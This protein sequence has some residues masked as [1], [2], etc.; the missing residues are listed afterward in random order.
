MSPIGLSC[1]EQRKNLQKIRYKNANPAIKQIMLSAMSIDL[2]FFKSPVPPKKRSRKFS[3]F[4]KGV[5]LSVLITQQINQAPLKIA[6]NTKRNKKIFCTIFPGYPL[7]VFDFDWKTWTLYSLFQRYFITFQSNHSS[8]T[9]VEAQLPFSC[10][11]LIKLCIP[12]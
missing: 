3:A 8:G 10:R 7:S 12:Y 2:D 6:P 5:L 11:Q 1:V 4:N 9:K